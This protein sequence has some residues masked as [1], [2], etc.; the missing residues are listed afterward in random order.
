M[1]KILVQTF[2]SLDG[3]MQ[4]PG[5]PDEDRSGGFEYGG[6]TAPFWDE[7]L[8]AT[9]MGKLLA[10][11][12]DLLLGRKTYDI[13]AGYW[14]GK[15]DEVGSV[16]NPARKWV[17][18]RTLERAEWQNSV[19]LRDAGRDVAALKRQSGPDLWVVGSGNLIQSL[20]SHDLVDELQVW[21]F[22]VLL[23]K[24]GR[25]FGSG[26][27]PAGLRLAGPVSVSG[28]GVV[29]ANYERAGEV[30]TGTIG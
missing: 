14:P 21:T 15:T 1:R 20:L 5:G 25:L 13:F 26:T 4:A 19:I 17:V 24:G 2:V 16:F 29:I 10:G 28:N 7:G 23:G 9:E 6:W 30:R 11:G 18:S 8:G 27:Q 22:P 3:V 12:Y